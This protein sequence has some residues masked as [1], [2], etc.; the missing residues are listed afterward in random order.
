MSWKTVL[1]GIGML[2]WYASTV[3][4]TPPP[5]NPGQRQAPPKRP[6]LKFDE[7]MFA[8]TIVQKQARVL[9]NLAESVAQDG[10]FVEG[11]NDVGHSP[12]TEHRAI[13]QSTRARGSA[14]IE[15]SRPYR[16]LTL[17]LTGRKQNQLTGGTVHGRWVPQKGWG[18]TVNCYL[19][20]DFGNGGWV[21]VEWMG[22]DTAF[23]IATRSA[24]GTYVAVNVRQDKEFQYR[25][26]AQFP[27]DRKPDEVRWAETRRRFLAVYE[28]PANLCDTIVSEVDELRKIAGEQI[29]K[30]ENVKVIDWRGVRS[31]N[32]PRDFPADHIPPTEDTKRKL[33][34][35]TL[36]ELDRREAIVRENCKDIYDAINKALPV[37]EIL[38]MLAEEDD[39]EAK[40]D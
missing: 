29:P 25:Y 22:K 12:W 35:Q 36:A 1:P 3:W 7:L 14:G 37:R 2:L 26:I 9:H 6:V 38:Q 10:W 19:G 21:S 27:R 34:E 20:Q 5:S 13:W 28:S 24:K 17:H 4:S 40:E 32:P 31:D 33:L 18:A 23:P 11:Y 8:N 15:R 39:T 30:L 16:G